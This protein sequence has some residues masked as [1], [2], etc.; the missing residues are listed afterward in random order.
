MVGADKI[1]AIFGKK[2]IID[3]VQ[4][5]AD[6]T[7]AIHVS[8]ILPLEVDQHRLNA[9]SPA[10]QRKFLAFSMGKLAHPPDEFL[11]GALVPF[12]CSSPWILFS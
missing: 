1:A 2:L 8:K 5:N 11:F 6:M 3:P 7:A 9:V 12:R 10:P 4:R